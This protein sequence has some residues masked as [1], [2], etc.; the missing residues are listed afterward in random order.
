MLFI[1]F[2]I[3]NPEKYTDFCM[4]YEALVKVR[5]L[6]QT[7][8]KSDLSSI[9]WDTLDQNDMD[10]LLDDFM[11]EDAPLRNKYTALLP[12][13][14]QTFI[15]K[16]WQHEYQDITDFDE[17]KIN[18]YSYLETD[19]EVEFKELQKINTSKG[20]ITFETGNFPFGGLDRFIM[21]LQA[22]KLVPEQC[23]NGFTVFKFHWKSV[24]EFEAIELPEETAEYLK[25]FKK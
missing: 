8:T 17:Q 25:S 19:F 10:A 9:N 23:Y 15:E 7:Q 24:Y 3:S 21:V 20:I 11:D 22:Y 5:T 12:S 14:V 1:T 4:L 13:Y 16:Q 2:T 6:E 18:L